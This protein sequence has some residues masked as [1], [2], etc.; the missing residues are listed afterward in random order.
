MVD[1]KHLRIGNI[2]S[3][4][5]WFNCEITHL[6]ESTLGYVVEGNKTSCT[7]DLLEPIPL[8][9]K[10]L[11]KCGAEDL[12][13]EYCEAFRL[14]PICIE[15]IPDGSVSVRIEIVI[16]GMAYTKYYRDFYLHQL[17]NLIFALTSTELN[18]T[19]DEK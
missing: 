13:A 17:Q 10:L 12:N 2:V 7:Y 1:K 3:V 6:G 15:F 18:F 14:P 8:T 5:N 11:I 9:P 4:N 16:N 19:P